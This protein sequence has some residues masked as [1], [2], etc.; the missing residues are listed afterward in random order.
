MRVSQLIN[1]SNNKGHVYYIIQAN[2]YLK[3]NPKL[4]ALIPYFYELKNR[5]SPNSYR[6]T[7][8]IIK[9]AVKHTLGLKYYQNKN[10][11]DDFFRQF[12]PSKQK[13]NPVKPLSKEDLL[14]LFN[15]KNKKHAVICKLLYY[16]G[17]RVSELANIKLSDI[18]EYDSK[19]YEI[20]VTCKGNKLNRILLSKDLVH[21]A[22]EVF[23]SKTYLVERNGKKH[24]RQSIYLMVECAGKKILKRKINPHLFR[25]TAACHLLEKLPRERLPAILNHFNWSDFKTFWE[26][27]IYKQDR[28][29]T[30]DFELNNNELINKQGLLHVI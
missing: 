1:S 28:I 10:Y 15:N 5:L 25:H 20:K 19:D 16:S 14:L 2:E 22:I 11:I 9:R 27:Y 23:N 18:R 24:T 17:L 26:Y 8:F 21:E 7:I 12:I 6:T 4:E 30:S 13:P 29:S 3:K